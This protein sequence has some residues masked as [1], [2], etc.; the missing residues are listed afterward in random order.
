[1]PPDEIFSVSERRRQKERGRQN[2]LVR[3][4]KGLDTPAEVRDRNG[5]FSALDPARAGSRP[6]PY[7]FGRL[8][9]EM[10][11]RATTDEDDLPN[12]W[13]PPPGDGL[14]ADLPRPCRQHQ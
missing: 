9:P 4:A 8:G 2:D 6:P 11:A 12:L 1:M 7:P 10:S 13:P 5:L 3:L 14:P